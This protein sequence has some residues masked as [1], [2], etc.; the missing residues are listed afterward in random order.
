[1]EI[2]VF[3]I[4]DWENMVAKYILREPL[5]PEARANEHEPSGTRGARADVARGSTGDTVADLHLT[6]SIRG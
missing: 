4:R 1:L 6:T 3:F 5:M 2:N